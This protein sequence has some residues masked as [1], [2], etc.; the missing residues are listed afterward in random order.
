VT[1]YQDAPPPG[2]FDV[3]LDVMGALGWQ[4]ARPLL[5]PGGRLALIT[6]DL[7]TMLG[8]ALRPGRD[9]RRI[10][11]GTSGEGLPAMQRLLGCIWRVATHRRWGRCCH[12]RNWPTMRLPKAST[13]PAIWWWSWLPDLRAEPWDLSSTGPGVRACGQG[14]AA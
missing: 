1:D 9:G 7:S 6:A 13:S 10:L 5:A 12:L 11:T 8:A 2:P 14:C 4:G 3:I